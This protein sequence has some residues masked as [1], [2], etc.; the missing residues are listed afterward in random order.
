MKR[1]R[2]KRGCR[3]KYNALVR[4][5]YRDYPGG[6]F[7]WDMPTLSIC[8]PNVYKKMLILARLYKMLPA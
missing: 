7:G 2:T 8:L 1:I 4:R 3:I 5:L 6:H